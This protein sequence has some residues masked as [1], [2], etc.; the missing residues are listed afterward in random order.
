[1]STKT[2]PQDDVA[3]MK[4]I[5]IKDIAANTA[6]SRG[7]GALPTLQEMGYGLFDPLPDHDD[8]VPIWTMLLSDDPAI[9]K[10]AVTLIQTCEGHI[11]DKAESQEAIG[12]L[13]NVVAMERDDG[14]YDIVA[15]M[16]RCIAI[17]YN[18]AANSKNT[19]KVLAKVIEKMKEV[20]LVFMALDENCNRKD[21][22]PIDKAITYK[23]LS[24]EFGIAT[25]DIAVRQGLSKQS[26]LDHLKLLDPMLS[27][28][29][30]AIH[31]REMSIE[32]A[33]KRLKKLKE[34]DSGE[35]DSNLAPGKRARMH[36]VKKLTAAYTSKKKPEW[37][38]QKEWEMMAKP[39]V[40]RWLSFCLKLKFKEFS[41][42]L[43]S[44]EPEEEEAPKKAAKKDSNGK[45]PYKIKIPRSVATKLLVA[46][47]KEGEFS[48]EELKTKLE[49]I[50]NLADET[51]TLDNANLQS[52]LTKL[53]TNYSRGINVEITVPVS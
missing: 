41:G 2:K 1:M 34:G 3:S 45:G 40:R 24:K 43:E 28:K 5:D 49:S 18:H 30:M 42:E 22:S 23:K 48:D 44:E 7:M 6:Q 38:D 36:S 29:L 52:T 33:L 53:L 32:A 10:E 25:K 50:V 37:M 26:I 14:T 13:Q 46:L 9:K 35:S 11:V 27:D 51:T 12:Q 15:G 47:G 21:E 4:M 20:D 39:D 31:N 16:L 8:K 17:A 19:T